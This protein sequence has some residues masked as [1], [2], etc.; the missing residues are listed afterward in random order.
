M[1]TII[2]V[3]SALFLAV[4]SYILLQQENILNQDSETEISNA[5]ICS[6]DSIKNSIS[7]EYKH[8]SL[9]GFTIN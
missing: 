3:I 7:V 5:L 2:A 8:D 9:T 4:A 1:N 6:P